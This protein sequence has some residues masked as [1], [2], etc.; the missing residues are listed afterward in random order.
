MPA[1][2]TVSLGWVPALSSGQWSRQRLLRPTPFKF[3]SM[4]VRQASGVTNARQEAK[5]FVEEQ[6]YSREVACG[7]VDALLEPSTGVTEGTILAIVQ[8]MA[9]APEIGVDNGLESMAKAIEQELAH[10][11]GKK[12]VTFF[13]YAPDRRAHSSNSS[14]GNGGDGGGGGGGGGSG[15]SVGGVYKQKDML[16][17]FE[18]DGT[19]VIEC[20]GY[21]GM[22]LRDVVEHGTGKNAQILAEYIECACAGIMACS[23]CHVYVHP[24]WLKQV[25][26]PSTEEQDMLD[27]AYSPRDN[28]RLGCQLKL[29]AEWSGLRVAV[30]A[31]A[32]NMFDH[33]PFEN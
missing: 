1:L 32:N 9:G 5:Q 11:Q 2:A 28:S 29:K 10:V 27:L 13:V 17:K 14:N 4:S 18:G 31:G 19:H 6:G 22:S 16:A 26:P 20:E 30:P 15:G 12:L 24:S 21:E 25:G 23:T 3:V 7:I 8:S 33:I